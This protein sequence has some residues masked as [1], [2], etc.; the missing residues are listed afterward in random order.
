[1]SDLSRVACDLIGLAFFVGLLLGFA[2]WEA[3]DRTK[4]AAYRAIYRRY[5]KAPDHE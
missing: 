2:I 4:W 5:Q 3:I 1:M